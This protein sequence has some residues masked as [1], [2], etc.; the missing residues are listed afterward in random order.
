MIN[1]L[2]VP[3]NNGDCQRFLER[4]KMK[5]IY[6]YQIPLIV[7]GTEHKLPTN[8]YRYVGTVQIEPYVWHVFEVN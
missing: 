4:K 5:T 7:L 6:N 3:T 2:A 8:T 1:F